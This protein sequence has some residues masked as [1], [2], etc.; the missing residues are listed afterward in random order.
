MTSKMIAREAMPAT[1]TEPLVLVVMLGLSVA[2]CGSSSTTFP[3]GLEPWETPNQA[4]APAAT[5]TDLFPESL[6]FVNLRWTDPTTNANVNSV[7]A[8]GYLQ[9]T[10]TAAF[11]AAR[12]PQ[13]AFDPTASDG[14]TVVA[15]DIEPAYRWTY[16][17]HVTVHAFAVVDWFVDWRHGV[18]EGTAEAPRVTAS[19]WQKT[20]GNAG[21][22]VL[23]GSLVL[24]AVDGHAD[25][26][27]VEYQYHLTAPLSSHTTVRN[28]LTSIFARLR[29]GAHGRTLSPIVCMDC[30]APP[31]GY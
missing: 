4:V 5:T 2:G 1:G 20:S 16:R 8:R 22:S 30:V 15:Y 25:V 18:V 3:S 17:T 10:L 13:T 27:A 14:F 11:R 12:D 26:T 24:R 6:S 9:V 7:H 31:A 21:I 29:D 19:R 23:E 28:Y